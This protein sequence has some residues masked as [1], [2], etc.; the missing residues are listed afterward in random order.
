MTTISG[1]LTDGAGQIINDCTIE[2]YAK[3]TTSKVLTQTQAFQVAESG[4]YS[5]NVL[6]CEY[7]VSLIINGFPKKR[8]GTIQVFSDSVDGTLNDY[9]LNPAENEVTPAILQQVFDARN[10][11]NK[12]ADRAEKSEKN[13]KISEI[14]AIDAADLAKKSAVN[15][16]NSESNV[17][18]TAESIKNSIDT[19]NN[20]ILAAEKRVNDAEISANNATKS[21]KQ[22]AD[23]AEAASQCAKNASDSAE[24]A[25]ISE[26][27]SKTSEANAA[28]S[29]ID[30][31]NA[32]ESIN[33]SID[34][35]NFIKK[36]GENSQSISGSL[37]VNELT[38]NGERVYSP[39][40][41]P[42]ADDIGALAATKTVVN[43]VPIYQVGNQ[44]SF[45]QIPTVNGKSVITDVSEIQSKL[46]EIYD[47]AYIVKSYQN[48]DSWYNKYSNGFIIQGGTRKIGDVGALSGGNVT[49]NMITP[50]SSTVLTPQITQ[51][52]ANQSWNYLTACVPQIYNNR[53]ILYVYN[54]HTSLAAIQ[55]MFKWLACG[56]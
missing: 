23:S 37:N 8:L 46:K 13:I 24:L 1:I 50:F 45:E 27:N 30:A 7:D 18:N 11:T 52:S 26:I 33:T 3:K 19:A 35:S 55:P 14:N 47:R 9:L 48:G 56:F 44:V 20:L 42:T 49:F 29:A 6:P 5:M 28:Q 32:A 16:K 43:N 22:S 41:K 53:F 4:E 25:K 31:K 54:N 15:V 40:N 12:A 21:A 34:T 38:E 10:E 17:A 36:S 51:I 39:N 2:L